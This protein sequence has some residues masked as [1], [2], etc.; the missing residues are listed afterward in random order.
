M[1]VSYSNRNPYLYKERRNS[2]L[3][4]GFVCGIRSRCIMVQN[5]KSKKNTNSIGKESKKSGLYSRKV[6][7][8]FSIHIHVC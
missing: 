5:M 6:S 4:S 3:R 1:K 2:V 7:V 8:L